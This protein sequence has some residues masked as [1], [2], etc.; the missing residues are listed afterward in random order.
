V[1]GKTH[2]SCSVPLL[3]PS[4]FLFAA[5]SAACRTVQYTVRLEEDLPIDESSL[6]GLQCAPCADWYVGPCLYVVDNV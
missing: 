5:Y 4:L 3:N 2:T 6:P 1:N